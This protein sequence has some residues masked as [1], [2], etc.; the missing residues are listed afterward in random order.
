MPKTF[1]VAEAAKKYGVTR[2]SVYN[3]IRNGLP[4]EREKP[5]GSKSRWAIKHRDVISFHKE[6]TKKNG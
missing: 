1:T 5:I 3:W 6:M 4:A 2:Q